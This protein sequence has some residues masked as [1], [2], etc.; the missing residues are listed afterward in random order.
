MSKK[1][2][3]VTASQDVS[4]I[5][6]QI[7]P[8]FQVLFEVYFDRGYNGGGADPITDEDIAAAGVTAAD[9]AAFTTL[10]ENVGKFLNNQA[11]FQSDY[12]ATINK[13]RT[14]V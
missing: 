9:V 3:F 7:A 4:T 13:I 12:Q 1:L 2:D 5:L 14:D 11:A 6:G 8:K 10:A